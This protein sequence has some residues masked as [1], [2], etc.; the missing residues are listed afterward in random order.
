MAAILIQENEFCK[1]GNI[2]FEIGKYGQKRISLHFW[3]K[4][5]H[6]KKRSQVQFLPLMMLSNTSCVCSLQKNKKEIDK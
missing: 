5:Q 3:K 2:E 4:A 1:K 6:T